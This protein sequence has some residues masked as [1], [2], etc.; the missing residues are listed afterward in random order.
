M[1]ALSHLADASSDA[2]NIILSIDG[3]ESCGLDTDVVSRLIGAIYDAA[4]NPALWTG[5]LK[6]I[7]GFTEGQSAGI[8]TR[9]SLN[10]CPLALYTHGCDPDYLKLYFRSYATLD[11]TADLCLFEPEQVVGIADF[12]PYEDYLETRFYREWAHPQGWV[13]S[14]S[15]VLEKTATSHAFISV[16]RRT[17][18]GPVDDEMRRR[19]QIIVPHVR[20]SVMIGGV[21]DL[22]AAEAAT[23][24]GVLDDLSHGV[25]LVDAEGQIVHANSSGRDMLDQ[26]DVL[27]DPNNVLTAT[28]GPANR[29]LRDVIARTRGGDDAVGARG[30]AVPL[31]LPTDEQWLAHV[32]P[33]T[34][35][36]RRQTGTT[37]AA[38]AAVFARKVA[39]DKPTT[40]ETVAK[41]YKLTPS[42]LRVLGAIITIGGARQVADALGLSGATVKT[43]LQHLFEKT[44]TRRQADLVKV[45]AG[46]DSPFRALQEKQQP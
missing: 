24:A 21:I 10:K 7:A 37:Y 40:L 35:G 45:V 33:L 11:P 34:S 20:R 3:K 39:L 28:D 18:N 42:E 46:H 16:Y 14:A 9:N 17:A 29:T 27:G 5:V 12:M 32:L 4:L 30:I 44:G 31:S 6:D 22:R 36:A 38:V 25:F 23:F 41:L 15:A 13:D 1:T 43:H 8:A 2:P 19:M 26:C